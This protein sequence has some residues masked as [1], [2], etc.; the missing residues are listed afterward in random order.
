MSFSF[1]SRDECPKRRSPIVG[2]GI[3]ALGWWL[4]RWWGLAGGAV[5]AAVVVPD[6]L[7]AGTML[8]AMTQDGA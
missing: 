1:V 3:L 5:I 6:G 7:I 8:Y 2:V 4:G